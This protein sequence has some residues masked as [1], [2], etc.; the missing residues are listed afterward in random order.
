MGARAW[1]LKWRGRR[2]QDKKCGRRRFRALVEVCELRALLAS[3]LSIG[4]IHVNGQNTGTVDATF[5]VTLS[6]PNFEQTVTVDFQTVDGTAVAGVDYVAQQGTLTFLPDETS[7]TITV[8][9]LSD[10]LTENDGQTESFTVKLSNAANAQISRDQGQGTIN[11]QTVPGALQFSSAAYQVSEDAGLATIAVL[12]TGGQAGGVSVH[13]ATGGG[14]AVPGTDYV[15]VSGTLTFNAGESV[16]TFTIPV[17]NDLIL[18]GDKTVG[19]QLSQ[20]AGGAFL[21]PRSSALLTIL[22]V[23]SLVVTN[24]RDAGPGSLRQAILTANANPGANRITFAIPGSGPFTIVPDSALPDVIDP[25]SIDATT[26]PGYRGRPLVEVDGERAGDQVS[27]LV[28]AAGGSAVRGLTINRFQGSGILIEEGGDNV[29]Q[30]DQLGTDLTG[31]AAL[32]NRFDGLTILGS[33]GNTIGGLTADAANVISGNGLVGL[34]ITGAGATSNLVAGNKIGTD[35]GGTSPVP[36]RFDG[37]FIENAPGNFIGGPQA[38]GNVISGNGGAGVQI[39]GPLATGN[40]VAG[41]SIGTDLPGTGALGNA[42]DGVFVNG[43][44]SNLIG[45]LDPASRNIISGN[46]ATGVRI[47]GA[48]AAGNTVQ[49]NLIGTDGLGSRSIGNLFDGIFID[50]APANLVGGLAPGAGN[51]ISG[52]GSVGIQIFGPAAAGNQVLGNLIGTDATG[53]QAV[54]NRRD[55]VFINNAP[56]NQLGGTAT[57]VRN[58][59]SGNGSS[60]LQLFRSGARSNVV[61]GN[62]IGPDIHGLPRLGNAFGLFLNNAGPNTIGGPAPGQTN[63]IA[64]NRVANQFVGSGVNA[65]SASASLQ[66][67]GARS[68]LRAP[69]RAHAA[70]SLTHARHR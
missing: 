65:T 1:L 16:K 54:R 70:V 22:N 63:L 60:G 64:G 48:A 43:S 12:R 62:F 37:V 35:F 28:L 41:N 36:N 69:R 58:V 52:N 34:R 9:I 40:H 50:G 32:P 4:D 17:L 13:F 7:K 45:G 6:P 31:R 26:Q 56:G 25:A 68:L 23:N 3:L 8:P 57:S 61:Q 53:T 67:L 15:P 49:G 39:F 55:G 5:T 29:I 42:I 27:G 66:R 33:A 59:I 14:S 46:H 51:L 24:T 19:L 21:G 47:A 11:D 30:A 20:P 38:Q 18:D 44:P 2:V 10:T